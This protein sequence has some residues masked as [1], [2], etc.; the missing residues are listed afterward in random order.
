LVVGVVFAL[1]W[2]I[3]FREDVVGSAV[4]GFG[5]L[6]TLGMGGWRLRQ[7]G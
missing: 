2:D 7:R 1:A 4:V 6:G 3:V 5:L